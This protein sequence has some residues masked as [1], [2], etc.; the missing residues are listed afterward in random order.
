MASSKRRKA[1]PGARAPARRKTAADPA[2]YRDL[3]GE[4]VVR[5]RGEIDTRVADG[6]RLRD[7][8]EARIE[9]RMS[10]APARDVL[11]YDGRQ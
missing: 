1:T 2:P 8:I 11:S 6:Q 4:Q 5:T 7:E 9:G 10:H 3:D